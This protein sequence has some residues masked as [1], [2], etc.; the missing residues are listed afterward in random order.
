MISGRVTAGPVSGT[1][2]MVTLAAEVPLSLA[3]VNVESKKLPPDA[4]SAK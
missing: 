3:T 1:R 4:P 2:R